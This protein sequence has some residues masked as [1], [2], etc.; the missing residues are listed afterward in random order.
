MPMEGFGSSGICHNMGAW[1]MVIVPGMR[2]TKESFQKP[3]GS[4]SR[5]PLHRIGLFDNKSQAA[6]VWG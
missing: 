6:A 1:T 2:D 5:V 3:D 4:V